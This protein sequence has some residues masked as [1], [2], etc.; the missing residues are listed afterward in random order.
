MLAGIR[1]LEEKRRNLYEIQSPN[2][3]RNQPH[4]S[5]S[6]LPLKPNK[7]PVAPAAPHLLHL[8][9]QGIQFLSIFAS[10]I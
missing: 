8:G 7:G 10:H 3:K 6:G 4:S 9:E 2:R 1:D 5:D